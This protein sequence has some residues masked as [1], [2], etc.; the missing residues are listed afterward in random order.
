[1]NLKTKCFLNGSKSMKNR[2]NNLRLR[3]AKMQMNNDENS[4]RY[5]T[6]I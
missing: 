4:L 1:M 6:L 3:E 5:N 2:L